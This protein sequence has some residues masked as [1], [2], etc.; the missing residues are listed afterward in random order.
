VTTLAIA[1]VVPWGAGTVL[2]LLD[3]RRR[4]VGWVAVAVLA[5]NLAA[6][7]VLTALVLRNGPISVTTGNWP[8]GVGI[9][10]HADALGVVFALLSSFV[11]LTALVHEVSSPASSCFSPPVSPVSF[12]PATSSTSTSSSSLR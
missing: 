3:G 6:L 1:L 8:E 10:L 5:G 11:V 4:V 2:V 7:G 9:T 12:S